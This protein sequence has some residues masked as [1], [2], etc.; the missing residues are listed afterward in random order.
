[1]DVFEK[2][3]QL[4]KLENE[5]DIH[6]F[7]RIIGELI[8]DHDPNVLAKLFELFELVD[9]DHVYPEI[10]YNLIHAV[11]SY[12][13]EL[14]IKTLL[15]NLYLAS[16]RSSMWFISLL[17]GIFNHNESYLFFLHNLH[18]ANYAALQ[19]LLNLIEEEA[20]EG[21][22]STHLHIIK[23]IRAKLAKNPE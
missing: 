12:P 17:Y 22:P 14:Y 15:S 4:I 9:E 8:K 6:E 18:Y 23:A 1:M 7:D 21:T 2:L 5:D 16:S 20:N 10:G 19:K 11:E 13:T 3:K